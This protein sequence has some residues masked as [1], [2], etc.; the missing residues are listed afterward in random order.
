M[1]AVIATG[2]KQYKVTEGQVLHIEML[3][4]EPGSNIDFEQVLLIGDGDNINIGKP[5]VAGSQVSAQVIEHARDKKI[6]IV[7][8]RRR[9]HSRKNMGHRQ[10]YTAVKITKIKAA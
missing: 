3:A 9:K 8:F 10:S 1:Y 6:R 7:K 4:A 5:Y 2:G